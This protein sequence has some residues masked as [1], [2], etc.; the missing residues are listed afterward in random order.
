MEQED[1]IIQYYRNVAS[2]ANPQPNKTEPNG[3]AMTKVMNMFNGQGRGQTY[4]Q[5][6]TPPMDY[7]VQSPNLSIM[8]VVR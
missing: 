2:Q 5:P 3:R 1:N 8:N 4:L 6:K 7:F